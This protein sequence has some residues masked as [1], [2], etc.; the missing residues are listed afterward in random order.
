M[1]LK[2]F[3]DGARWQFCGQASIRTS[4]SLKGNSS[5]LLRFFGKWKKGKFLWRN[6]SLRIVYIYFL[7]YRIGEQLIEMEFIE[8]LTHS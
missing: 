8:I 1:L 5:L 4:V 2:Q 3:G 7:R 6:K